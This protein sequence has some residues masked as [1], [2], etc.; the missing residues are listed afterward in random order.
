MTSLSE[1]RR[2]ALTALTGAL[3]DIK[4]VP[5]FDF[6]VGPESHAYPKE[7]LLRGGP[8]HDD[9]LKTLRLI[10]DAIRVF[11]IISKQSSI[12]IACGDGAYFSWHRAGGEL[13]LRQDPVRD[14]DI[15]YFAVHDKADEVRNIG[16]ECI[17]L[18]KDNLVGRKLKPT[19][20][21]YIPASPGDKDTL[22]YRSVIYAFVALASTPKTEKPIELFQRVRYE[23]DDGSGQ[24]IPTINRITDYPGDF[25]HGLKRQISKGR[26]VWLLSY[27]NHKPDIHYFGSHVPDVAYRSRAEISRHRGQVAQRGSD[28]RWAHDVQERTREMDSMMSPTNT[29]RALEDLKALVYATADLPKGCEKDKLLDLA[30]S[31]YAAKVQL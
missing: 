27:Q 19:V 22:A 16:F 12:G 31:Q 13:V 28:D 10:G 6:P 2:T 24:D 18:T 14:E 23:S 7:T 3:T 26:E 20:D 5:L 1:Q 21:L 17:P 8:T 15:L 9:I 30:F 29:C 25:T 11:K 4:L